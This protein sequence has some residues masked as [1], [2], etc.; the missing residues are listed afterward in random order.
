M[1][2]QQPAA[3]L[4]QPLQLHR[5]EVAQQQHRHSIL[6]PATA[7]LAGGG[8]VD[9]AAAE[10]ARAERTQPLAAR[11][12]R[13]AGFRTASRAGGNAMHASGCAWGGNLGSCLSHKKA[14]DR[15]HLVQEKATP[16]PKMSSA[17]MLSLAWESV[18]STPCSGAKSCKPP[19][20]GVGD[21]G[22]DQ[23]RGGRALDTSSKLSCTVHA[24]RRHCGAP[25][26]PRRC[27]RRRTCSC[28]RANHRGGRSCTSSY[29]RSATAATTRI[30]L[31]ATA[32]SSSSDPHGNTSLASWR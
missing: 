2:Q 16:L 21:S 24:P 11:Q 8:A 31:S 20:D 5:L 3:V 18:D 15:A 26:R 29:W 6:R 27:L 22:G 23:Q 28:G 9:I 10:A 30:P 17:A 13:M 4:R 7:V 25:C 12:W 14:A 1:V 32:W 19:C